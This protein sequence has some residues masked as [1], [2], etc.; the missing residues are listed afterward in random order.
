VWLTR[1]VFDDLC[2][3]GSEVNYIEM[4]GADHFGVFYPG[5]ELAADWFDARFAGRPMQTNSCAQ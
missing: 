1:E 3:Q 5:G 2:E 4:A